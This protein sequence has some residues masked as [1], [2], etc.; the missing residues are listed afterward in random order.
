MVDLLD[1]FHHDERILADQIVILQI[2]DD[3]FPRT[4]LGHFPQAFRRALHTWHGVGWSV[5]VRTDGGGSDLDGYVHPLFCVSNCFLAS[6]RIPIIKARL[7]I[8]GDIHNLHA[9]LSQRFPENAQISRVKRT[10]MTVVRLYI[11]DVELFHHLGWE[12]SE[13]H[14]RQTAVAVM[15]A[16]TIDV[17]PKR[18]RCNGDAIPRCVRQ[19]Y[20]G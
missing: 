6:G 10:K 14:S 19:R 12:V 15:V 11:A 8:D 9:R 4:V 3:I 18:I 1:H 16:W 20:M 7:S 5:N 13:I 17:G 2:D